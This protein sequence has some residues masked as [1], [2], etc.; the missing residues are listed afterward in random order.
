MI[1]IKT[2]DPGLQIQNIQISYNTPEPK[3]V[4]REKRKK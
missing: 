4:A 1:Q 2:K 3:N